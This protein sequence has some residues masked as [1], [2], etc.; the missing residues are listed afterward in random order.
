M[1]VDDSESRELVFCPVIGSGVSNNYLVY[2]SFVERVTDYGPSLRQSHPTTGGLSTID[3]NPPFPQ[4][5]F[6]EAL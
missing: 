1:D 4:N 5:P 6:T 2:L 3:P